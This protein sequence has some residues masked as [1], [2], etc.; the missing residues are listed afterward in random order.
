ML[1]STSRAEVSAKP[2]RDDLAAWESAGLL[3]V[4]VPK[5]FDLATNYPAN[6]VHAG[7]L[8]VTRTVHG[9]SA[10]EGRPLVLLSFSTTVMSGQ[11]ALIQRVC[12]A[13]A[14]QAVDAILTLGPALSAEAIRVP[15]NIETSPVCR[16]RSAA[17]TLRSGRDARRARNDT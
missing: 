17:P 11:L 16:S 12:D 4:T 2:A 10:H 15:R 6:V 1:S 3:L 7:P 8:G 14:D 13:I 9:G 5:W